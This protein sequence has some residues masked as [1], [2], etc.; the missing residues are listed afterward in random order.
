MNSTDLIEIAIFLNAEK[1]K[2]I[3]WKN[4]DGFNE[5]DLTDDNINILGNLLSTFGY[6]WSFFIKVN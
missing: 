1:N 2:V 5:I 6:R 3:V 4:E